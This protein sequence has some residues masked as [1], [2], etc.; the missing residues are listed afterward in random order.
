VEP[1]VLKDEDEVELLEALEKLWS[2]TLPEVRR[3]LSETDKRMKK[4]YEVKHLLKSMKVPY[5]FK[6]GDKVVV[7]QLRIGKML[8]KALGPF[9]F[10]KYKGALKTIAQV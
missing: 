6:P 10:L 8:P 2:D 7:R 1:L 9:T 3:K 5:Y 4:D